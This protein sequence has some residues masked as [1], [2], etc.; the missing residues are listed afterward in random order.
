MEVEI[1]HG[2]SF[3]RNLA[4]MALVMFD[5]TPVLDGCSISELDLNA[6][7]EYQLGLS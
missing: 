5:R 2:K 3:L 4:R 6:V 1:C 7:D